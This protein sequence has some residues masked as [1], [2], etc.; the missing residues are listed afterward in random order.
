MKIH[1]DDIQRVWLSYDFFMEYGISEG[2]LNNWSVRKTCT[3]IYINN[4]AFINYD[5]IPEQTRK[6]LPSKQVLRLDAK[7]QRRDIRQQ[8]FFNELDSAFRGIV[9]A[10]WRNEIK[11]I[12]DRFK[13]EDIETFARRAAIFEK[14]LEIYTGKCGDL[15]SLHKAYLQ[16]YPDGYSMKN[17]F[18][19]ALKQAKEKGIL[20]VAI[21]YKRL[22]YSEKEHTGKSIVHCPRT[23]KRI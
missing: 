17:R 7:D 16:F 13:S 15:Q 1:V 21:D 4:R 3:R 20:S 19:M 18:C 23:P 11:K 12:S 10:K 8:Y 14:A 9:V 22:N 5:T 6:K 2:C